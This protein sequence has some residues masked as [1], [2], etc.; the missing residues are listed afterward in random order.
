MSGIR[1]RQPPAFAFEVVGQRP[2]VGTIGPTLR[3][4][5]VADEAKLVAQR[6]EA[7]VAQEAFMEGQTENIAGVARAS[8]QLLWVGNV[9]ERCLLD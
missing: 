5:P 2:L 8:P 7:G 6:R 3:L 1:G 4:H 9:I